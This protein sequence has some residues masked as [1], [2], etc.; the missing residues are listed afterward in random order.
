MPHRAAPD[1]PLTLDPYYLSVS[2]PAGKGRDTLVAMW[3]KPVLTLRA[4]RAGYMVL[5]SDGDVAFTAKASGGPSAKRGCGGAGAGAN[6][7]L[8]CPCVCAAGQ[9]CT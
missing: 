5:L 8:G 9:A 1:L 3:L 4:L 6:A 7:G 2:L